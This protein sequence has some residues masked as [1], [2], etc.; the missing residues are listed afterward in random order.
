MNKNLRLFLLIFIGILIIS[1]GIWIA[2]NIILKNKAENFLATRIPPNISATYSDLTL[3]I[4]QGTLTFNEVSV[5]LKNK[6]DDKV[7]TQVAVDKFI[8][9]DISYMDYVFQ[10][11]IHIEDIKLKSPIIKY[12]SHML[13]PS[14]DSVRKSPITLY[15]PVLIDELS[16]DNA[17]LHI[18]DGTKDSISLYGK[19]ITVEIDDILVNRETLQKRL[20]ITFSDYEAEGDSIFLKAGPYENLSS[21]D[22]F[23]KKGKGEFNSL[24]LQTKYSKTRLSQLISKER[25]HFNLIIPKITLDGINFGFKNR[26][27]FAGSTSMTIEQPNLK[28]F[29]DKT[30]ADD[31]TRKPLYSE[32][33]RTLPFQLTMEKIAI[34]NAAIAYTEKVKDDNSG[35][36]INFDNLYAN[37]QNAS[38]TYPKGTR[39][40]LDIKSNFMENTSIAVDW[41]FDVNN[42]ADT[43][44][45]K[46]DIGKLSAEKLNKFTVPNLKV[47]M[48][49]EVEKTYFTISG[50]HTRSHVDMKMRYDDFKVSVLNKE[51]N[52]KN[53]FLSAIVNIFIKKESDENSEDF[54]EGSA[55][56][57]RDKT[58]SIFNYFW[59][60]TRDGLKSILTGNDKN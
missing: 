52:K 10:K 6:I 43:F 23:I 22:F 57:S 30:V 53:K 2:S 60:N 14:K 40:T 19:N 51:G 31:L 50:D 42:T 29:R 27:L 11:E 24:S 46:A 33:L 39:T 7:H 48:E 15:K 4:F 12:Y 16:I 28:I 32:M 5:V 44:I 37:I 38:N 21:G 8:I 3:N 54:R 26:V 13:S 49:G 1:I 17:T 9:E 25:D 58:K 41:D 47:M 18:Y 35:G 34:K 36:T 45:F 56:V 20:P 59:L 55:T